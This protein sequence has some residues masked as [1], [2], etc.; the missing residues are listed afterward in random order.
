MK[1]YK[2]YI[3]RRKTP[4]HTRDGY[5]SAVY[6]PVFLPSVV[7]FILF[8]LMFIENTTVIIFFKKFFFVLYNWLSSS[9]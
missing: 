7:K 2:Y 9:F 8:F 5:C 4:F 1:I 6:A 3:V